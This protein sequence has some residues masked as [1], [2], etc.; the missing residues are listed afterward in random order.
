MLVFDL[1]VHIKQKLLWCAFDSRTTQQAV[2]S[3]THGNSRDMD[4]ENFKSP[5]SSS[6]V[7]GIGSCSRGETQHNNSSIAVGDDG[8][9]EGVQSANST[10]GGG[11]CS[12]SAASLIELHSI[13]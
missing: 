5:S 10:S 9:G 6:S 3:N 1:E 11:G 13:R 8:N 12:I 2:P 4:E 7:Y